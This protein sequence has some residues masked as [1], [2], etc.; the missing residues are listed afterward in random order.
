M[1][2]R[3]PATAELVDCAAQRPDEL[4][5]TVRP[6]PSSR[7]RT[8]AEPTTTPSATWHTSAACSGVDTPTPTQTGISVWRRILS[9]TSAASPESARSPVT[10]MRATA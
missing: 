1:M 4:G 5:R 10:P 9:T 7:R 6:A 2:G 3:P 8:R